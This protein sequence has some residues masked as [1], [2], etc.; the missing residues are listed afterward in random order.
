MLRND[1]S[2]GSGWEHHHF[3]LSKQQAVAVHRDNVCPR[4]R[5]WSAV[6]HVAATCSQQRQINNII[7]RLI[8]LPTC[9][10]AAAPDQQ[11]RR[12]APILKQLGVGL[13]AAALLHGAPADAGVILQ[14]SSTKKV[15]GNVECT[16]VHE[17]HRC[18]LSLRYSAYPCMYQP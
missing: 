12:D 6:W 11:Q 3:W 1:L 4:R 18:A 9:P 10:A 5:R 16:L 2:R 15:R 13:A 7:S 8:G 14:K 17:H